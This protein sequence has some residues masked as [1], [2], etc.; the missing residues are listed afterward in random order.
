MLTAFDVRIRLVKFYSALIFILFWHDYFIFSLYLLYMYICAICVLYILFCNRAP[1]KNNLTEW[2]T[3]YKNIWN[4]RALCNGNDIWFSPS[5]LWVILHSIIPVYFV[6][7][8]TWI[9]IPKLFFYENYLKS[10][11]ILGNRQQAAMVA[12]RI[13]R[14]HYILMW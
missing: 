14:I 10:Y 12:S 1:W 2:L 8:K 13:I 11:S 9:Y 4:N 5:G 7:L 3:L 6:S